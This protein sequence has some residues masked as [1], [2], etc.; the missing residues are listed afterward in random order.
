MN[1]KPKND[2]I[3]DPHYAPCPICGSTNYR[4]GLPSSTGGVYFCESD[5]APLG[6]NEGLR[7]RACNSCGNVQLFLK[8]HS[9]Q[10]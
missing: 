9:N 5:F 10:G 3:S 8:Y 2:R 1:E 4:W 6:N 7:A